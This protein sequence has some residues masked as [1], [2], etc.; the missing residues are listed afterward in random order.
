MKALSAFFSVFCFLLHAACGDGFR[1]NSDNPNPDVTPK[2]NEE[3]VGPYG[4]KFDGVNSKNEKCT[5]GVRNFDSLKLMCI[6]IQDPAQNNDCALDNRIGKFVFDCSP[7]GYSFFESKKCKV[8]LI[9]KNAEIK[10]FGEVDPKLILKTASYCTGYYA[11]GLPLTL[12]SDQGIFYEKVALSVEMKFVPR[13]EET[14]QNRSYFKTRMHKQLG[15]GQYV[16]ITDE[17]SFSNG[18]MVSY[19]PTLDGEYKYMLRCGGTWAC[20]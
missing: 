12:V 4:Y 15:S 6:N 11:N 2:N 7:E 14:E 9:D 13:K 8:S 1:K 3:R 16:S 20:P 17:L 18:A 5:T 19:G 10:P